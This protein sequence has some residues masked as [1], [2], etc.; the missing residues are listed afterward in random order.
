MTRKTEEIVGKFRGDSF[1]C[2]HDYWECPDT[3]ERFTT[4]EDDEAWY[5]QLVD[6]YRAKYGIPSPDEIRQTRKKYG[7]SAAKMADILG[8]GINQYRL[9]EDGEVPS[10]SAGKLLRC[11]EDPSVFLAFIHTS[12]NQYSEKDYNRIVE[13]VR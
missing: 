4:T 8:M 9:Y 10:K 2:R 7:L 12:R 1:T 13:K 3:G 5:A 11:I 6:Q